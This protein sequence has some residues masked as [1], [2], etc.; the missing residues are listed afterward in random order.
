MAE[1][2]IPADP[3]QYA[4]LVSKLL[5]GY[6]YAVHLPPEGNRTHTFEIERDGRRIA[7]LL[8]NHKA[9]CNV[10][11]I[12]KFLDFL[13][14]PGAEH[15]T[16]GWIV[17]TSGFSRP[18]ITHVESIQ[19]KKLTLWTHIGK[20]IDRT[21]PPMDN[22]VV[23]QPVATGQTRQKYFGI[24]TCK[25]G[26][27]KTTIAA[28]LAG[29]FALMGYDVVLLDLDPEKNLRKLFMQ[30][31]DDEAPSL[32]VPSRTKG[33]PGSTITVLDHDEWEPSQYRDMQIIICDCSPVLEQNPPALVER[34]DYCVVPTTL[35]PLGIAKNAD[36]ITRTFRHI[37]NMNKN[38]AMF[39]LINGYDPSEALAKKNEKLLQHLARH[40]SSYVHTDPLC[41]FIYPDDA[42]I[43]FSTIL[44]Y[45]GF[46]LIDGSK[47]Q[48]AFSEQRGKNHPRTDFLKLA[49]YLE[50]HTSIEELRKGQG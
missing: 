22:A 9:K 30:G 4:E 11:L 27:G 5:A 8:K 39:A 29:A 41:R 44:Q 45:W 21:Y 50:D 43:R 24:F 31:P 26:V 16:A 6:R 47:P 33:R 12:E 14:T 2:K 46:H 1:I 17:S 18:A 34:F 25:G 19:A 3:E 49:D 35:T 37:R 48:L 20:K 36:V 10:A 42:V 38:A 23:E 15:F 40:L 28:H 13:E 7:V 32:Y